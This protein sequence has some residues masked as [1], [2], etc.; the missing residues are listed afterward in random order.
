MDNLKKIISERLQEL[1]WNETQNVTATKLNVTQGNISKWMTAQQIPTVDLL[2]QISKV[3]RVSVD[4]ILGLKSDR[5]INGI[6]VDELTYEQVAKII[7]RLIVNE[8]IEIPNLAVLETGDEQQPEVDY[9][10]LDEDGFL[11]EV[12]PVYD[13]DY[14]KVKDRLLSYLLRRRYKI[15]DVGEDMVDFWVNSSLPK[16]KEVRVANYRS[17]IQ[18]ALDTRNWSAFNDGDWAEAINML[19]KMSEE[20]RQKLIDSVKNKEK[21]G[22]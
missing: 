4:W 18:D 3:Y 9:E 1:F 21:D 6:E 16:F 5:E 12:D 7:D 20:E 15:Y 8:N 13:S 14:L 10:N 19:S 17:N 2:Y 22:D 11:I